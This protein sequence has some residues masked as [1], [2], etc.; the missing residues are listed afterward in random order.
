MAYSC[1]FCQI[2]Q[3]SISSDLLYRDELIFVVRDVSPKAPVHIL[4]IPVQH[5][6][7][8][9]QLYTEDL[10]FEKRLFKVA[11]SMSLQ[12]GLAD[13]GYRLILN[14]GPDSGQ[15]IEHLHFHLLGGNRLS[16]IG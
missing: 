16:D 11:T 14:Q 2:A 1:I 4:L 9:A 3:G 8:L 12:M 15:Q 13:S 6:A 10:G 7:S 5:L